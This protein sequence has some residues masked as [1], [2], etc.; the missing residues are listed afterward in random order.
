MLRFATV[1]MATLGA[2]ATACSPRDG[3]VPRSRPAPL[4]AIAVAETRDL[5][6]TVRAPVDLRPLISAEVGSKTLGYLDAVLVDRGDRVRRGQV[7]A[8]VRPSDLPDQLAVAR[9]VLAQAQSGA[10]LARTNYERAAVLAP[11]EVVSKQELQQTQTSLAAAEATEAAARS[12]ISALAVRLGETRIVSPMAGVVALRR[13]DPGALV[14]PSTGAILTV[15]RTDLLRVFVSLTE[16]DSM[17][18]AVGKDAHVE[19]DALPGRRFA[20]KV[21]RVP[22]GFDPMTRTLEVEVQLPNES[23]ELRSGMYGRAVVVIDVHRG[24]IVVPVGAVVLTNENTFLYVHQAGVV[25]RRAVE[26]GFDGDGVLEIKRGLAAGEEV[27]T[28]GMDMVADGAPVRIGA[29][30]PAASPEPST[31]AGAR[32]AAP[33]TAPAPAVR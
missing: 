8:L 26:I 22:P 21:V 24:A 13:F 30:S 29:A 4:V 17:G 25:R 31:T 14:G 27:V 23:G 20:G 10:A 2:V 28:A 3:K 1:A 33:R 19:L 18:V 15:V 16:K 5:P 12:Q 32:A 11:K 6:V 9:S 7:L